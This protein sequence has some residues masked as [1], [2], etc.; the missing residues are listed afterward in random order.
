MSRC[1]CVNTFPVIYLPFLC[2]KL[3]VVL[4]SVCSLLLSIL[5]YLPPSEF[6]KSF[7]EVVQNSVDAFQGL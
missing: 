2:K 7:C 4:S 1:F 6:I 3:F 5:N